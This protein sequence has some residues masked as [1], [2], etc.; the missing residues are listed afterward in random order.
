[1]FYRE[2]E[3]I[4][5]LQWMETE[6]KATCRMDHTYAADDLAHRALSKTLYHD[7]PSA[8]SIIHTQ[9]QLIWRDQ[10]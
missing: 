3:M 5:L 7:L 9:G 1:M 8:G 2:V 4:I 10:Q 6:R